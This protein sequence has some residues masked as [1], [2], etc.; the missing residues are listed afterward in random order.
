M[1]DHKSFVFRFGEFEVK[2]R[3]F[4]LIKAGGAVPVEPKAFRVLLFLLRNP[5]RL[6][7]KDEILNA[8]WDDCSVSD[9]SLTRS[10]ATL[11]R[12][13]GDD[14]HEPHYIATVQTVGY[15]FLCEVMATEDFTANGTGSPRLILTVD[16]G[17]ARQETE[18]QK[19][20][21]GRKRSS[22]LLFAGIGL[23]RL[24]ILLGGFLLRG[25]LRER[26]AHAA[27]PSVAAPKSPGVRLTLLTSVPGEVRDP[28]FSPDGQKIAFFWD[29][30]TPTHRDL[31]MQLVGSAEKPLRL[32]HTA[33]G[34]LC[35]ANWSP[36][37]RQ[38]VFSRCD[39]KGGAIY[40]VPALGGSARK[41]TDVACL[42]GYDGY[43]VGTPGGASLLL[44]DN[45]VPNGPRG[46]VE[47]S[48]ATAEK[49][50]LTAPPPLARYPTKKSIRSSLQGATPA[51]DA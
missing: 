23:A 30:E 21:N 31:Y 48:L 44:A 7:K 15:R 20:H 24:V 29:E 18:G 3:E 13:L 40:V 47:F 11:R 51:T 6:V 43:P 1:T 10:I 4:L 49:R 46:I 28:A 34:F 35:C 8:V 39:D 16:N 2:E 36:D 17:N 37:G 50:C 41:I 42:L 32:T 5:G 33:T 26:A 12:L 19:S 14:P 38:I 27:G 45:C 22:R 25:V 9:N